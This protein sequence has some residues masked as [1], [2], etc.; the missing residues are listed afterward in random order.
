MIF[1]K[2]ANKQTS[3]HKKNPKIAEKLLNL[4]K[5]RNKQIIKIVIVV[6]SL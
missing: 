5:E 4:L 1:K 3:K 2:K 6:K